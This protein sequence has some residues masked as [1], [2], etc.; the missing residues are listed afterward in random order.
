MFQS[1]EGTPLI[2]TAVPLS[3][4]HDNHALASLPHESLGPL[5]RESIVTDHELINSRAVKPE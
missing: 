3:A 4:P 5:M 1:D 2:R